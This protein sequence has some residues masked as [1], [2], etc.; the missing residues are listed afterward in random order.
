[1]ENIVRLSGRK[2]NLC[3]YRT[4]EE[5]VSS[6]LE[7]INNAGHLHW[8]GRN[9]QMVTRDAEQRYVE[10][11]AKGDNP[12]C[13]RFNI[14]VAG[15]DV[16]IGNCDIDIQPHTRNASLGILIGDPMHQNKGYGT[17]VM[18]M[19]VKFCFE[20]LGMHNVMLK[21]NGDNARAIHVYEKIGFKE[22][23][24]EREACWY[25]GHWADVVSMQILEQEY[26]GSEE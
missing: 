3:T 1:M 10:R 8:L 24:R 19:L 4:D 14:V 5:A 18:Q 23:G 9:N 25:N 13:Y 21:A 17:E 11:T 7:W 12:W 6:Y 2:V 20:E 15:V 26:F 22:C 16:L